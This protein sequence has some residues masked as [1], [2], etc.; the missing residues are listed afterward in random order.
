MPP[1]WPGCS[2]RR[3]WPREPSRARASRPRTPRQAPH[4]PGLEP[5][6]RR[7]LSTLSTAM[8]GRA[9]VVARE[10]Q[11]LRALARDAVAD[12][13]DTFVTPARERAAIASAILGLHPAPGTPPG[14]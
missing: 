14:S 11:G 5:D 3:S 6:R 8:V 10:Q 9:A 2:R 13:L 7:A 12:R 1:P 4:P